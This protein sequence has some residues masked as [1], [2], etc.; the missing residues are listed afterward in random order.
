MVPDRIG[1]YTVI[2]PLAAGGMGEVYEAEQKSPRRKVA[3]KLI[4]GDFRSSS[5]VRRFQYEAEVL[6]RLQ[7][8][9]IAQIFE[10]G[11]HIEGASQVPFFAME[12]VAHANTLLQ[13][14]DSRNLPDRKRLELFCQ[15][16]EA[17]H[18]GHLR[19]II[20]RDLKPDNLLVDAE[21]RVKVI[22][23]GLARAVDQGPEPSTH[24]T[25]TGQL[26]G[27]LPYM[28]PEQV[29]ADSRDL[30]ARSDVYA[31]GVVLF[32]LLTGRLPY[33]V[34]DKTPYEAIRT[35]RETPAGRPSSF[36]PYLRGDIDAIL[37]KALRK[38]PESRYQSVDELRRDIQ[39]HLDGEPIAARP[40]SL[41]YQLQA[42]GRRHRAATLAALISLF[43][44]VLGLIVST[45]LFFQAEHAR[46][47]AERQRR[48]A[49]SI[50]TFLTQDLLAA[51]DPDNTSNRKIT[52]REVLDTASGKISSEQNLEPTIHASILATLGRTYLGLGDLGQAEHHLTQSLGILRGSVGEEDR[53]TLIAANELGLVLTELGRY[54]EAENLLTQTIETSLKAFG[55][56]QAET[57][58][59]QGNLALL[60]NDQGNYEEALQISQKVLETRIRVF[61]NEHDD[62]LT[63]KN[64]LATLHGAQGSYDLA[65]TLLTEVL[66]TR[67]R[68][69]G[70][71]HPDTFAAMGNLAGVFT[72]QGKWEASEA[73]LTE[74]IERSRRVLGREHF[75]SL[76][77][78][79]NL[80]GLY[81][82]Q[83]RTGEAEPLYREVLEVS[84]QQLG[85]DHRSTLIAMNNLANVYSDQERYEQAEAL[86]LE[87]LETRRQVL[88]P[89][90][91][92]TIGS[93][94]NLGFHYMKVGRYKEA[95]PLFKEALESFTTHLGK[96]HPSTLIAM[97]NLGELYNRMERPNQGRQFNGPVLEAASRIFPAGHW[98]VGMA[99]R[100]EGVSLALQE[101]YAEAEEL[102]LSSYNTLNSAL[103]DD[104]RRTQDTVKELI[105]L[106]ERWEKQERK[107]YWDER[108]KWDSAS[109]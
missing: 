68:I 86:H 59:T 8:P 35:I 45:T 38:E 97:S 81:E 61:G 20:H 22:D 56:D 87:A 12:F 90:N 3:L 102:L 32:E 25:Q 17:V 84:R 91:P 100:R 46:A 1:Q 67:R 9:G 78:L 72:S 41:L 77:Y 93:A 89:A 74:V 52:V 21:G 55:P 4:R 95:E 2:R 82:S 48:I 75:H 104:N 105:R 85:S 108:A 66:E 103:G 43:T 33:V 26:L 54:E 70:N 109:L 62:T 16:C 44:L 49:E 98:F 69:L 51:V 65:E 5:S 42:L 23:F 14:V 37:D 36:N 96:D 99:Q 39:S 60:Q 40:A 57:L 27:T 18:Y 13:Y 107:T 88:G 28:S 71:D 58:S 15:A 80:A 47:E 31:L 92:Q 76:T 30:D 83:G 19:G 50:N 6:A 94:N 29:S 63:V 10:A 7:H 24:H 73:L 64:N 11:N 34:R 106:Y 101:K 53:S 79:N